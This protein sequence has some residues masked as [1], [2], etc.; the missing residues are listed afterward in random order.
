[1][2]IQIV[3]L[4]EEQM[5][6]HTAQYKEYIQQKKLKVWFVIIVNFCACEKN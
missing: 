3:M 1:M 4:S 6:L 2:L 5:L